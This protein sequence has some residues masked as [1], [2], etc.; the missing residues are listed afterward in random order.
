MVDKQSKRAYLVEISVP[1]HAHVDAF[2]EK[3]NNEYCPLSME[4]N[5]LWYMT[6][7]IVLVFGSLGHMHSRFVSRFASVVM[8]RFEAK[9]LC[10]FLSSCTIGSYRA[11]KTRYRCQGIID[12]DRL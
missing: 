4:I 8:N 10:N 3:Q 7:V 1:F 11:W 9:V 2:Y 6:Y 12:V 5:K